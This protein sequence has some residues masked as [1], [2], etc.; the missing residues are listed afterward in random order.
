MFSLPAI[1]PEDQWKIYRN[2]K[3]MNTNGCSKCGRQGETEREKEIYCDFVIAFHY[4]YPM[5]MYIFKLLLKNI[6]QPLQNKQ[7]WKRRKPNKISQFSATMMMFIRCDV[8]TTWIVINWHVSAD[9]LFMTG[10][11][12]RDWYIL[13]WNALNAWNN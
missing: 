6:Q 8:P 10:C 11:D 2:L 7:Q 13:Y 4:K 9:P 3:L 12:R 5:H 1:W